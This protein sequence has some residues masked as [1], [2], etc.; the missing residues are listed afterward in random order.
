MPGPYDGETAT[1]GEVYLLLRADEVG[2]VGVLR[3]VLAEVAGGDQGGA[4]EGFLAGIR[5]GGRGAGVGVMLVGHSVAMKARDG[6][7]MPL[8]LAIWE[9]A[10]LKDPRHTHRVIVVM[11]LN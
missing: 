5:A 9:W 1:D 8:W 4:E 6:R 3:D 7:S 11:G 2:G 10:C